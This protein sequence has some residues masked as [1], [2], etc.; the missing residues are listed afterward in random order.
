MPIRT[1]EQ[2]I[3][4]GSQSI[5]ITSLVS[6]YLTSLE[7]A[8]YS[9]HYKGYRN[10]VR[11]KAPFVVTIINV[12]ENSLTVGISGTATITCET[13]TYYGPDD[14]SFSEGY[15]SSNISG[16]TSHTYNK[17]V[18]QT[19]I[20]PFGCLLRTEEQMWEDVNKVVDKWIE[21]DK[22]EAKAHEITR[23]EKKLA[24]VRAS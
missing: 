23:L 6:K 22:A 7:K 3:L 20:V 17:P 9:K 15:G 19:L 8:A 5:D 24:A 12:F 18:D 4:A 2:L 11:V 1:K 21:E 13:P 10:P 14:E 16:Y